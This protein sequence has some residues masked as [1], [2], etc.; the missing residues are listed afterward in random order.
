M[1]ALM[2]ARSERAEPAEPWRIG[3]LLPGMVREHRLIKAF[4]DGLR[5]LGYVEGQNFV[6]E[7]RTAEGHFERLLPLAKELADLKVDIIVAPTT[8]SALAAQR[9]TKS[10]PIVFTI[11]SD[12]VGSG[13]VSSFSHPGGNI[14]GI[15]DVDIDLAQKRLD[16][17]KQVLPSLKRVGALGDPSDHNWQPEWKQ[18]RAAAEKLHVEI[19]PVLVTTPHDLEKV[20]LGLNKRVQA[21]LVAPQAFFSVHVRSIVKLEH[22]AKLPAIH[23]TRMFPDSGALMSYGPSPP[24]LAFK[25]ASYVDKILKGTRPA[26]LPVEQPTEYEL[27]INLKT[28]KELGVTFPESIIARADAVI[29]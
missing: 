26:D 27:V 2:L 14:T 10:I 5:T 19:V 24:A 22:R 6:L 8:P 18:A 13:L 16:L 20:F 29:R 4:L 11:V 23:E 7:R 9:A 12:P 28:A 17:L 25:A 3:F 1:G 21:L 15:T